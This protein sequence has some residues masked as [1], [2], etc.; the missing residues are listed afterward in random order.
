MMRSVI[1]SVAVLVSVGVGRAEADVVIDYDTTIDYTITDSVRIVEGGNPNPPTVVDIVEPAYVSRNVRA[2]DFSIVN[3][4]GGTIG[5]YDDETLTAY[6]TS[7]VNVYGGSLGGE[8]NV[9]N[10]GVVNIYGGY[11]FDADAAGSGTLNIYGGEVGGPN[12]TDGSTV[13]IFDGQIDGI[14]ATDSG[15]VSIHGGTIVSDMRSGVGRGY[16]DSVITVFGTDFNY[17][18]GPI[19]E[20]SGVLTGV[21]ANGGSIDVTF[22]IYSDASIVLVPEPCTVV[23]LAMGVLGLA[24]RTRRRRR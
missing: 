13:N 15:T 4:R 22:E 2:F 10:N 8:V 23:L 12:A 20:S 19:P 18:Y 5:G 6:D 14:R 1:L 24:A 17:P 9:I 3:V 11:V 7:T 21:P 16:H